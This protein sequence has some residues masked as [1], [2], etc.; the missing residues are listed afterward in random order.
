M[1]RLEVGYGKM[2]FWRTKTAISLKRVKTG[3]VTMEGL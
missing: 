1:G 2:A 3:N